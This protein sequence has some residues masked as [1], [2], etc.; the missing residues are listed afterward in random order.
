MVFRD[1]V[2][3]GF[4]PEVRALFNSGILSACLPCYLDNLVFA[5]IYICAGHDDSPHM[6]F[7]C[8]YS[9]S[10]FLKKSQL[11]TS[12][13]ADSA[14]DNRRPRHQLMDAESAVY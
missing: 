4:L 6:A 13:N 7:L 5:Q 12:M 14:C 1:F 3:Q 8:F 11:I 9:S 2:I 10:Q